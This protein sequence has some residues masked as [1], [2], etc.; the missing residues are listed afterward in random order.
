MMNNRPT[1]QALMAQKA[2]L[3]QRRLLAR[4]QR[5]EPEPELAAA[6]Q[7]LEDFILPG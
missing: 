2:R 1:F 6:V 3:S 7:E 4:K 5:N